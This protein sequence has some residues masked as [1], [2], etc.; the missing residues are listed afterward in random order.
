[1]GLSQSALSEL[2]KRPN[3]TLSALQ[4]YIEALG[5]QLKIKAVYLKKEMKNCVLHKTRTGK[6]H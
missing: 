1:M 6:F 4:R 2:E 3:I 5:G